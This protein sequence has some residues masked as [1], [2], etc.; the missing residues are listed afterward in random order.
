MHATVNSLKATAEYQRVSKAG[1]R[2]VTP[3]FIL[4][5][6]PRD[7]TDSPFRTGLTVS[8]KVG[9]AVTRNRVKRRLRE[10]VRGAV[11]VNILP[12]FDVVIIGR[13]E[14]KNRDFVQ[15]KQDFVHALRKLGIA[16]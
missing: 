10:M 12:S 9:N 5:A 16:P 2:W 3:A 15:M 4:L 7:N 6:L 14:A 11:D 8:R 13:T 1:K